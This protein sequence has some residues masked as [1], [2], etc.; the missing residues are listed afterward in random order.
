ME[1]IY[2]SPKKKLAK[3]AKVNEK[4]VLDFLKKQAVWQIYLHAPKKKVRP[5]F[6]VSTPNEVHQAE[7]LLLLHDIVGRK[8]YKYAL[9]VVEI[10]RAATYV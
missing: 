1:K 2:Y 10:E 4:Q 3:E 7:L 6:D 9:T 5:R 8:T